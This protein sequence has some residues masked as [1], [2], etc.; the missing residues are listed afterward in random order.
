M[1]RILP[2]K[3]WV[4]LCCLAA[5]VVIL[6][7]LSLCTPFCDFYADKVYPLI[8]AGLGFVTN[9]LPFPLGELVMYGAALLLLFAAAIGVVLLFCRK[10]GFVR[11]CRVFYKSCAVI[12]LAALL[13]YELNWYLVL[14]S[15]LL[16]QG[17]TLE[18]Q[19]SLE[20]LQAL[21]NFFA[22]TVN[23][24]SELVP[25]D[26]EGVLI[27]PGKEEADRGAAKAL[28][29]LAPRFYRLQ[30]RYY[31]PKAAVC[32]EV[33]DAMDIG[34]YTYPYTMEVTYN[35]YLTDLYYPSLIAHEQSHHKGYYRENE[36]VF[37]GCYALMKSEDPVLRY[38][39]FITAFGFA[40]KAYYQALCSFYDKDEA[41]A[42]YRA[43]P[44]L[45]GQVRTDLRL[46]SEAADER[47]ESE[48]VLPE[49]V[50]E[51][52][53]EVSKTGWETQGKLLDRDS[54]DGAV[55]LFLDYLMKKES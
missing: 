52:A 22:V 35:R 5:P 4:K 32:S 28:A 20:D 53:K 8:A 29:G 14:K 54:Y 26:G 31:A 6:L 11:F 21:R 47:R 25:R 9:K 50:H 30:G 36:A 27:C 3:Y 39:G 46:E 43:Q 49:K 45:S 15:S 42:I 34:G 51:S 23:E 37:L 38:S 19:Y 1:K 17:K 55:F 2:G 41:T 44:Q 24:T 12:L 7:L 33:L 40:D 48:Q 18:R 16:G 10:Q 13:I